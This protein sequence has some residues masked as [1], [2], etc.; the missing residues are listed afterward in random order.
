MNVGH[1]PR[2]AAKTH[3]RVLLERNVGV[4]FHLV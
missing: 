3:S 4:N 1:K 2:I